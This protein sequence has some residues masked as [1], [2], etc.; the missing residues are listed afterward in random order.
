[1]P[2]KIYFRVFYC[3]KC[4][5]LYTKEGY[6]RYCEDDHDY[7]NY[8]LEITMPNDLINIEI[9]EGVIKYNVG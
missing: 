2:R 5:N 4:K 6:S 7:T 8:T 1:M 3:K 9:L